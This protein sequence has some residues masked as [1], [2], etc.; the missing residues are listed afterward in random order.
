MRDL[1]GSNTLAAIKGA[2][3]KL[4]T[5]SNFEALN[6]IKGG[7]RFAVKRVNFARLHYLQGLAERNLAHMTEAEAAF[8]YALYYKFDQDS[9]YSALAPIYAYALKNYTKALIIYDSLIENHP[10]DYDNYLNRGFCYQKL[11]DHRA[12]VGDFDIFI[13]N[14]GLNGSVIF[15]KAVSEISL[16]ETD[17]ACIH[18]KMSQEMG[19]VNARTFIKLY[20]EPDSVESVSAVKPS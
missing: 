17:S 15:L 5:N 4:A 14:K 10:L 2:E 11:S 3:M 12:A 6:F 16:N 18:F 13:N 9:V 7:L 1:G 19:I 20:C 8:Q